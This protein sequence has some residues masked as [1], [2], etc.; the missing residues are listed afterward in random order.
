M[1]AFID[2]SGLPNQNDR[3]GVEWPRPVVVAACFEERDARNI[4]GRLHGLKR[5]VLGRES[6]ELKGRATI[7]RATYRNS[8]K[9][10]YRAFA[11]EFFSA[12]CNMPV[13]IFAA[14]MRGPF[15]PASLDNSYLERRFQFLL[16]RIDLLAEENNSMAT[17]IFDG[18][19]RDFET[20]SG[21]FTRFLYRSNRGRAMENITDTP[22][23]V[24]SK[25][26]IGIQ[27]ADMCAYVIRE[28]H[29]NRLDEAP[30]DRD[31]PDY[32]WLSAIRRWYPSI[33]SSS[34]DF[35]VRKDEMRY[36]FHFLLAGQR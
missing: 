30:P 19:Q 33:Y 16:E 6:A 17:V 18:E 22:F 31:D 24:D 32:Y 9:R 26:S 2:E 25:N 10:E 4:S 27:I 11:A 35:L 15:E 23:F 29:E 7:D 12:V 3:Q 14:I 36:G 13:T 1:L 34:R 5:D 8:R 20:L 28:Y 21:K